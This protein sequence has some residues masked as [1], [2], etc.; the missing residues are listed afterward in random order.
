[1]TD[2][3]Y[4]N[5]NSAITFFP[6]V[7]ARRCVSVVGLSGLFELSLLR[8]RILILFVPLTAPS[9]VSNCYQSFIPGMCR[10][11]V[12][13]ACC[14][15]ALCP[16][17]GRAFPFLCVFSFP[18]VMPFCLFDRSF[19]AEAPVRDTAGTTGANGNARP[20]T[21]SFSHSRAFPLIR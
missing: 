16:V 12:V 21:T 11:R 7:H 3:Q 19:P 4:V 13:P 9:F 2:I 8:L 1:M 18:A 6:D 10:H 14:S 17:Y 5:L 15:V 20:V